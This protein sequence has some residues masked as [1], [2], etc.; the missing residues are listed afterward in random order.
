MLPPHS[1]FEPATEWGHDP[2]YLEQYGAGVTGT[3][4]LR[5]QTRYCLSQRH[6]HPPIGRWSQQGRVVPS[7][8]LFDFDNRPSPQRVP[9]QWS[10]WFAPQQAA[11]TTLAG[12]SR[13]P[14]CLGRSS[15]NTSPI[16]GLWLQHL[17]RAAPGCPLEEGHQDQLQQRST[18]ANPPSGEVLG[19]APKHTMKGKRN[20]EDFERAKGELEVLKRGRFSPIPR[21][22]DLPRRS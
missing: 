20:E 9:S 17:E 5:E 13:V 18:A 14:D 22:P 2:L 8:G 15:P 6:D 10:C 7:L 21:G 3:T 19:A 1:N 12:H 16:A 11:R 4:S